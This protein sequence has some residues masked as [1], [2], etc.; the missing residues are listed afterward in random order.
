MLIA[1]MQLRPMT[2]A[3]LDQLEEIDATIESTHYMH[4]EKSGEPISLEWKLEERSLREKLIDP[5]RLTDES[6]FLAKQLASG[7]D[8]GLALVAEHEGAI[9]GLLLAQPEPARGTLILRDLRVDYDHRREGLA[10][11]MIF[12]LIQSARDLG[13][14][15][16]MAETKTNNLPAARLLA[17][18]GFDLAGVDTHRHSNHDLVKEAATLLWYA[19]LD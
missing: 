1:A 4:L 6:R 12:Q 7:A 16:A 18:C 10:T 19:A 3:D 9:V 11:A 14:R 8:E 15:A 2:P 13:L 17:K 5:F